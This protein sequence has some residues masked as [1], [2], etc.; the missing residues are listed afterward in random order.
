MLLLLLTLLRGGL[1][2]LEG[3]GGDL[4]TRVHELGNTELLEELEGLLGGQTARLVL[5]RRWRYSLILSLQRG[6]LRRLSSRLCRFV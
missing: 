2:S 1:E 5:G 4:V 3:C 6:S